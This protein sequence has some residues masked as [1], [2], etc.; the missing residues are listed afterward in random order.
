MNKYLKFKNEFEKLGKQI[1]IMREKRD[2]SL[3]D[4]SYKTGIS[5]RYLKKIENG[6]A[7]RVLFNRH[8]LKIAQALNVS[9]TDLF[10][11]I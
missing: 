4:L 5:E 2:I 10:K 3:G 9:L 6:T 7:Y 8:I 1:R 11:D